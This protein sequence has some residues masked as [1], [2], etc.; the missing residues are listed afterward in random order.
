[1]RTSLHVEM[2]GAPLARA[3]AVVILLHGRGA[4]ADGMLAL[5]KALAQREFAYLAPQ[6]PNGSWYPYSFLAPIEQNEPMLSRSLGAIGELIETISAK[7]VG[8]ERIV[9]LG[10]SQGGCLAL[11]YAARNA[12][13]YGAVIGLSAGLI[14]LNVTTANYTGSLADTP[15]FIG[16]SDIDSHIPLRRVQESSNILRALGANVVERIYPA[17]GHTINDDE[18][19]QV[20]GMLANLLRSSSDPTTN[21]SITTLSRSSE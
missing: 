3:Q 21:K 16:C 4:T 17:M 10:F 14:G 5:S 7:G 8:K 20:Y 13:R 11:E 6:A 12:W 18:I 19:T 2:S 15:V 9:L 1:M